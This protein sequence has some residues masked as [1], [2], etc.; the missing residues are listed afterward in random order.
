[1]TGS[2]ILSEIAELKSRRNAV[3]M[4]HNYTDPEVQDLADFVGDSLELSLRA[5]ETQAPCIVFCGVSFMAETAKILAPNSMVLN[6]A[7][8][9]GCR[10]ADMATAEAV[11]RYRMEHPDAVL[12]AYVNTT[13]AVKAEVDIC[14]TSAN[15]EKVISSIPEG[16][17]I[18]FLPDCHLGQNVADTLKR[19]MELWPGYCPIHHRITPQQIAAARVIHPRAVVLVHPECPPEV[20]AVADHALS[21]GG[22]LRLVHRAP[23]KEFIVGTEYGIIHRMARENPD[24]LFH[25]LSPRPCCPDMKQVSPEKIRDALRDGSPQVELPEDL[26][27]RARVAIERMLEIN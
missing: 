4:A 16:K 18:M 10:M 27:K 15:A 3:I 20:T 2:D 25:E 1:M 11:R 23:E 13:A 14:C 21:T 7:P 12:V 19:R 17:E 8:A 26:M 5:R 6:P 24:K 22:M 9:A